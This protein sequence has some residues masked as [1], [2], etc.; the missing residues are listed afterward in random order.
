[1]D[2]DYLAPIGVIA[3]IVFGVL[4]AIGFLLTIILVPLSISTVRYDKYG[5]DYSSITKRVDLNRVYSPGRYVLGPAHS[6]ITIPQTFLT[7]DY[8]FDLPVYA[9]T[10]D[11]LSIDLDVSFQYRIEN[12][13]VIT[14]FEKFADDYNSTV[15]KIARNSIRDTASKYDAI[16]F[17]EV[18]KQI[19]NEMEVDLR[20]NLQSIN[21][22][23]EYLQLRGVDLPD[24]YETII[25]SKEIERQRIEL[26]SFEQNTAVVDANTQVMVANRTATRRRIDAEAEAEARRTEAEAEAYSAAQQV[27][28]LASGFI[29]LQKSTNMSVN[30]LL[31]YSWLETVQRNDDSSLIVNLDK[32][33]IINVPG[34]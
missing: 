33:A 16:N 22:T 26:S 13:V 3:G 17:F 20:T 6:F 25:E 7:I 24:T 30:D 2:K 5:L 19:G 12:D 1:M 9:R 23:L 29:E 18:R 15:D 32:P 14:V 31:A 28:A 10:N 27:G 21:I 11:G 4:L 8:S 34:K